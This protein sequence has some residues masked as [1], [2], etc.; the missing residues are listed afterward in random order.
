M[1]GQIGRFTR[2]NSGFRPGELFP[3]G[4][5]PVPGGDNFRNPAG[6]SR[7]R[8]DGEAPAGLNFTHATRQAAKKSVK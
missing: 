2:E 8:T 4:A 7:H 6:G 3:L 1:E 5:Y